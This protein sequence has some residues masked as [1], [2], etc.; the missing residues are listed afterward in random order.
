MVQY[1]LGILK[2]GFLAVLVLF[3]VYMI[4][5]LKRNLD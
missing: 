3:V 5:L 4:R 1:V 2:Y